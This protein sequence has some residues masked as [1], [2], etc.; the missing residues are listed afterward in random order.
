MTGLKRYVFKVVAEVTVYAPDLGN[1]QTAAE[2][3][4]LSTDGDGSEVAIDETELVE[5]DDD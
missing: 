1:A 4:V 2:D 5:G 3:A